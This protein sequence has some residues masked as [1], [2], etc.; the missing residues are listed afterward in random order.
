M[1]KGPVDLLVFMY[2]KENLSNHGSW[3]LDLP[4]QEGECESESARVRESESE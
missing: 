4:V 1:A 2:K 3:F